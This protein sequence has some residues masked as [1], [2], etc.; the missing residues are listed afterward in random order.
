[1][2]SISVLIPLLHMTRKARNQFSQR[3]NLTLKGIN[4]CW[5]SGLMAFATARM[6]LLLLNK[7]SLPR[8]GSILLM[9]FDLADKAGFDMTSRT[10]T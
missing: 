1:M 5:H 10:I 3:E 9:R 4:N 6:S 7:Y 2:L 8:L